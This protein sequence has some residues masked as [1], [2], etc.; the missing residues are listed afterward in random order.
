MSEI[1]LEGHAHRGCGGRYT[2]RTDEVQIKVSGMAATVERT[3]YECDHCGDAQYTVEQ[4]DQAEQRAVESIRTTYGLMTPREI[5]RLRE[6][7]G[8]TPEQFGH[9]LYGTPRGVVEGWER[10]RYLQNQ[11]AD[12]LMRSLTDRATLERRASRGG[13][14]LPVVVPPEAATRAATRAATSAA[15]AQA[16]GWDAVAVMEVVPAPDSGNGHHPAAAEP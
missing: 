16:P 7:L 6:S 2:A 4:R 9:L 13:V 14:T 1:S 5:R 8:L 15:T 10:G 12:A 11:D 3:R